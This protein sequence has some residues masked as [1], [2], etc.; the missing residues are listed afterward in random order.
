MFSISKL[1]HATCLKPNY[2]L[3]KQIGWSFGSASLVLLAAILALATIAVLQAGETVRQHSHDLMLAQVTNRIVANSRYLAE[4]FSEYLDD[5]H[6]IVEIFGQMVQD[7]IVNYPFRGWEEDEFVPFLDMES[8]T[9]MYPLNSPLLN[10]DWQVVNNVN[11]SNMQEHL[12]ERS[13]YVTAILPASS[14]PSYFMQGACNPIEF[15]QTAKYYYNSCTDAN[16]DWQTGGIVRPTSVHAGI[17]KKA[18]DLGVLLK[19]LYEAQ[20][21]LFVAGIFFK[22]AGA[23]SAVLYPGASDTW[24]GM[25]H[26]YISDGCEWMLEI[27]PHSGKPFGTEDEIARCH[28]AGTV[29]TPREVGKDGK[30]RKSISLE[31]DLIPH[32]HS[33]SQLAQ[34][35]PMERK[36][37]QDLALASN[38]GWSGMQTPRIIFRGTRN[39]D[40]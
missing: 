30:A 4:A 26:G 37:C 35:N 20:D 13:Q 39:L 23:G 12:Q 2:S 22:N 21:D 27:N 36:W 33:F 29:V 32:M 9:R 34:Y 16:N 15:D 5:L 19:P 3:R 18:A 8:G 6:G 31:S 11:E 25:A 1:L 10:M 38:I 14:L 40:C 24:G 17:Y 7:R 28:P